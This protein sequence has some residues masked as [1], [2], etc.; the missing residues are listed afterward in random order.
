M[1]R[2]A[3]GWCFLCVFAVAAIALAQEKTTFFRIVSPAGS[4]ISSFAADGKLAWTNA[5]TDNVTCTVQRATT[6]TGPSNWVDYVQH[7]ATNRT[8]SLRVFDPAPPQ[9]MALVPAGSFLMGNSKAASDNE[10]ITGAAPVH[11]VYVSAFY[12]GKYEISWSGWRAVRDWSTAH[13][14]AYDG[15][16]TTGKGDAHPVI[17]VRWCDAV[18]WCNALSEKEGL[19]PCY[20]TD[21]ALTQVYR[22]GAVTNPSVAWAATGYRLPT[23][24]EWEKAA[25]GGLSEKRF[26]WGDTI[27]HSNANYTSDNYYIYDTS[28]T[29][30]SHPAYTTG[31]EPY[32][33]PV[34]SFAPNGYGLYDMA[35][36][37]MEWCWDWYGSGYYA[38]SPWWNPIG[39]ASGGVSGVKRVIRDGNWYLKAP[40]SRT[41]YRTNYSPTYSG[42]LT[43]CFGFRVVRRSVAQ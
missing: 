3:K 10:T 17:H 18:K 7:P 35:G 5:A 25:R 39:P 4:G 41:A 28:P 36:N 13:G 20:F 27:T 32:T 22:T 34:G 42:G 30:G 2:G 43:T 38:T 9:D 12:M 16:T 21:T 14:Y 23:E 15:T 6:L 24:A 33:S 29:R 40:N 26:P 1:R 11:P 31:A 8:M 37:A 19:E